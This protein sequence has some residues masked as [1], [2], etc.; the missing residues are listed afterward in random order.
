MREGAEVGRF[1]E[2][3][4]AFHE[5]AA[6]VLQGHPGSQAHDYGLPVRFLHYRGSLLVLSQAQEVETPRRR[7]KFLQSRQITEGLR[8]SIRVFQDYRGNLKFCVGCFTAFDLAPKI[9]PG[10]IRV[11]VE[12]IAG[13][14]LGHEVQERG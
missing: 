12:Y 1:G 13:E 2:A 11:V 3:A 7:V 9:T 14:R 4:L 6:A 8:I 10:F 5:E